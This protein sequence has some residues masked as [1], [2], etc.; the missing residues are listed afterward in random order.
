[1]STFK[2]KLHIFLLGCLTM[3]IICLAVW[4]FMPEKPKAPAEIPKPVIE[5]IQVP[6]PVD[7]DAVKKS[8][9]TEIYE[10]AMADARAELEKRIIK[11]PYEPVSNTDE[12][13]FSKRKAKLLPV[14]SKGKVTVLPEANKPEAES[15]TVLKRPPEFCTSKLVN[16]TPVSKHITYLWTEQPVLTSVSTYSIDRKGAWLESPMSLKLSTMGYGAALAAI[17]YIGIRNL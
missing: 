3:L 4:Y 13:A 17:L 16:E 9:T 15:I 5:Y 8:L 7:L 14:I 12:F 10:Q 6:V 2:D 1:M 11:L